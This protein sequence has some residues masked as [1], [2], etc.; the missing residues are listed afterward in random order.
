MKHV[1]PLLG[2]ALLFQ[3]RIACAN[4]PECEI[5]V[6]VDLT[7]AGKKITLPTRANP[8]YYLPVAGGFKE[9]GAAVASADKPPP[10]LKVLHLLAVA[11]AEQGYLVMGPKTPPPSVLLTFTWGSMNPEIDEMGDSDTPAEAFYNQGQMLA[12]VGG[13]T[14]NNLDLYMEREPVMQGAKEDR[15]FVIVSA[16]DFAAA[17]QRKKVLLWRTKMSTPSA[18]VTFGE[19]VGPLIKSGAPHFGRETDRPVWVSAPLDHQGKVELGEL[20]VKEYLGAGPA[21]APKEKAKKP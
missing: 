15:F 8:A 10:R 4:P 16:Y 18:R 9:E 3:P 13:H 6:N 1:L 11:L 19:V 2:L 20:T 7:E 12:L 5:N 21:S 14:L 17:Q